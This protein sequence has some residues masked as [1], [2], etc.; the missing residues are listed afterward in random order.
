MKRARRRNKKCG[1]FRA[2]PAPEIYTTE[3][4]KAHFA[5]TNEIRARFRSV[6]VNPISS[7]FRERGVEVSRRELRVITES[8]FL[9]PLREGAKSANDKDQDWGL[10][11][12]QNQ[13]PPNRAASPRK[14]RRY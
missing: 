6:L 7:L 12:R 4:A 11:R 9:P 13:T 14:P 1:P 8:C 10:G 2:L 5:D 3:Y